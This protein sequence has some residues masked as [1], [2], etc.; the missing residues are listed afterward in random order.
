MDYNDLGDEL[1]AKVGEAKSADELLALAAQ[2]GMELSDEQ[3]EAISG[4]VSWSG[5]GDSG[6]TPSFIHG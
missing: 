2:E 5:N 6:S 1:K 4:G 3:L